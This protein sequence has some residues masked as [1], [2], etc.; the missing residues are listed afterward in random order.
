MKSEKASGTFSSSGASKEDIKER[1]DFLRRTLQKNSY[2][3]YVKD[4]PEISDFEYDALFR[5][6]ED[7]ENA[8]PE[9]YDEYSPTRRVGGAASDKFEK[10]THRVPL[11]SL[12]DVFSDGE[13]LDFLSDLKKRDPNEEFT[14]E[15]KIDGLSVS[16]EYENG[17][18]VRGAT[19]GDGLVGE[20]VTENIKT[21][22]AIP[23]VLPDALPYLCVRG[24]VYMSKAVFASLNAEREER[25]ESL[26]ANPRNAAAGS[27]RLL[28]PKETARRKLSCFIFN[29][30]YAEGYSPETHMGSLEYLASQGFPVIP[31]VKV[32]SDPGEI[33]ERIAQL[34]E[35]RGELS[36]DIDGAVVKVNSLS[37]RTV[38]GELPNVPKWAVAFKYPPEVKKSVLRDIVIQVGR[39][40]VLTPNAVL[41]P[42]RLAGTTVSRATLHNADFIASKDIRIGDTVL[43]RKAGEIIP[44]ILGVDPSGRRPDSVPYVFP[45]RCPV[46]SSAVVREEGEA[47]VRCTNSSCPAQL[48]RNVIH[49]A[50]RDAMNIEG[51]GDSCARLLYEKKLIESPADIYYLKYE[52]VVSLEGFADKSA[53]NLLDAAERSKSLCLSR[54]I[55]ALGIRNVGQKAA[56]AL[57][58]RFR[59]LDALEKATAGEITLVPDMGGV[60]AVSVTDYFSNEKNVALLEKLKAAGVNTEYIERSTGSALSG[61][62]VVITGTL[63]SMTRDEATRLITE[64]GGKVSSSV[65]KK[66]SF[67]LVGEDAGSKLKKAADLGVRTVSEEELLEMLK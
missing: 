65:S 51:L 27:L 5:E 7:L 21:I 38:I 63:P 9:F 52:D 25:G 33:T 67:V 40:G 56:L 62:T 39:T 32:I 58:E 23:L 1:I 20:D 42:V 59:T 43:V 11:K 24:E 13:M 54:L 16:L 60:T 12:R 50:S 31:D 30:Q 10:V 48:I 55:Y 45:D 4:A 44:E 28:D 47:A 37:A 2:L 36:F 14:V 57:A 34:G 8:N 53:R 3:Y 41:D 64:N 29:L 22:K 66:T 15:Y 46:C 18:F 61:M 26:F 49:F 19:R 35:K 6:L 17:R